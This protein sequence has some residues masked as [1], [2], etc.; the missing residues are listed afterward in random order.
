MNDLDRINS[1]Y[2]DKL[3]ISIMNSLSKY[4]LK[5]AEVSS[6]FIASNKEEAKKN[7]YDLARILEE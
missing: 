6:P 5:H 1:N 3:L 4:V 7:F 2:P